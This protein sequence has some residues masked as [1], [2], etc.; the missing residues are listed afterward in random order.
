[1]GPHQSNLADEAKFGLVSSMGR[2]TDPFFR[3]FTD[4]L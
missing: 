2:E 4:D 3:Q 1:M